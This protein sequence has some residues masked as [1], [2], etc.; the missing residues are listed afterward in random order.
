MEERPHILEVVGLRQ[1][2]LMV[3]IWWTSSLS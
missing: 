2:C 3:R 1:S